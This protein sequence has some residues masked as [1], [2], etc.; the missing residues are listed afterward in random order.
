ME[1]AWR[2]K[3][4]FE[5]NEAGHN[6]NG[7]LHT[8]LYRQESEA[9]SQS[10]VTC[11]VTQI[12]LN[13]L[14]IEF[15]FSGKDSK[16]PCS[17]VLGVSQAFLEEAWIIC[18]VFPTCLT[19]SADWTDAAAPVLTYMSQLSVCLRISTLLQQLTGHIL[20]SPLGL[21]SVKHAS[22]NRAKLKTCKLK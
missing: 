10:F 1:H 12:L 20:T 17:F 9:K 7:D 14:Q 3:R 19:L 13:H 21:Y 18:S 22:W 11:N 6:P 4:C 16:N 15:F 2:E 8:Q 5:V